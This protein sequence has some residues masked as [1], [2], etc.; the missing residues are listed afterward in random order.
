ML[1][2]ISGSVIKEALRLSTATVSARSLKEDV[3]VSVKNSPYR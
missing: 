3:F 2:S 1:F